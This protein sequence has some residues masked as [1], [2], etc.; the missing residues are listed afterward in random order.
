MQ[1]KQRLLCRINTAGEIN[2]KKSLYAALII[3][4]LTTLTAC[5]K[6][7]C[8]YCGQSTYC[9]EYD[10]L[11]TTRYICDSCLGNVN[12]G[13]SGN[14]IDDYASELVD[15]ALY[16]PSLSDNVPEELPDMVINASDVLEPSSVSQDL[17]PSSIPEESNVTEN[18][19]AVSE[20]PVSTRSIDDIVSAV[21][22]SLS[23]SDY[24]I[25]PFDDN[26]DSY[27][28]YHGNDDTHISFTF[29]NDGH[30]KLSVNKEEGGE[31][32]DF[33]VICIHASLAFLGSTDYDNL[34]Y[35]IYNQ[36]LQYSNY[37]Q[38]DCHFLFYN[39]SE[40][41]LNEGAPISVYEISEY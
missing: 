17:L 5:A 29:S 15:P 13:I 20:T 37:T 10:I 14:V 21:S 12:A 7:T 9:T 25:Q 19:P 3:L 28:I 18:E 40:N 30:L 1:Q 35:D 23:A 41:E 24:Y 33:S 22:A 38:D 34:G 16:H 6:Q 27:S 36:T 31:D 4:L 8:S 26:P 39:S 11:G 2:M 32:D